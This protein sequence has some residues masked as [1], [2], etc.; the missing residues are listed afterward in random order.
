MKHLYP[1]LA[2]LI[3]CQIING[4]T[5][6]DLSFGTNDTFEIMTWNL[7]TFPKNNQQT[8]DYVSQII[9]ALDV[10]MVVIQ[11]ITDIPAFN[12]LTNSLSNYNGYIESTYYD[13]LAIL[14]KPSVVEINA[15]YRIYDTSQY[16][17]TFPRAPMVIDITY[18]NQHVY[19]IN[20][21]LKCCG[22]GVLVLNNS[23]DEEYRRYE[24]INLLKSYIDT[25]LQN[26][27]VIVLGDMNDELTDSPSNNVFQNI[28]DDSA[29]YLFTDYDIASGNSTDWSYPS[30]PS[31]LDHILITNEL[32]DEFALPS[33]NIQTI[34]VDD[35]L[36][37]GFTEYDTNVSDHRPVALK[38]TIDSNLGTEDL[39]FNKTTSLT[40]Y[41]NPFRYETTFSFSLSN[42]NYKLEVVNILGQTVF[43]KNLDQG[44]SSFKW[45]PKGISQGIYFARLSQGNQVI[46][47]RKLVL[48][49]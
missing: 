47:T 31:H 39:S 15:I 29:D 18:N 6:N 16:W 37:G 45:H 7:E 46:A 38:L 17:N 35:Y 42:R 33:A 22:D 25:N 11:E 27:N 20:N 5:L 30:W 12:Q 49:H 8:V 3:F 9:D 13:G 40:N 21:H 44:Q 28:L 41:P 23:S 34:K 10:D 24:A 19:I 32:F 43:L 26:E 1:F 36:S 4:Q 2:F 14:Y 48:S